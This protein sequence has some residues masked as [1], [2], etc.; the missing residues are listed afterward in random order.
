MFAIV[1]TG[2]KQYRVEEGDLLEVELLD[3]K[4]INDKSYQFDKVV[5]MGG[6]EVKIGQPYLKDAVVKAT[7]LE[8]IKSDKIIVFKKK[9][10]KQ[11]KRTRGHRQLL[12]RVKIDS[13]K[14]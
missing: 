4:K 5:F 7:V 12:H 3:E 9:S 14:G 13:I 1:E 10:K 11:Y 6:D 2:G 8:K